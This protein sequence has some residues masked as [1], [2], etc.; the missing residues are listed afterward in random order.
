PGQ[1]QHCA[2][3]GVL[4]DGGHQ[5]VT[6]GEVD[7]GDVEAHSRTSTPLAASVVLRSGMAMAPEWNTLAASAASTRA[8][9]NTS[10]KCSGA[11]APPEATSGTS[12][13]SRTASSCVT[14]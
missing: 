2:A 12:Q 4:H 3:V 9:S 1:H 6:L 5:A 11:P 7:G 8:L 14:S 10:T 13:M